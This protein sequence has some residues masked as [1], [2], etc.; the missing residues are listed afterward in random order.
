MINIYN[1]IGIEN[2]I[3]IQYCPFTDDIGMLR[4]CGIP[5]LA[6]QIVEAFNENKNAKRLHFRLIGPQSVALAR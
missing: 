2:Q 3:I 6:K 1:Y 5:A 4:G